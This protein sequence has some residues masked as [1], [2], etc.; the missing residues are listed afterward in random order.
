VVDFTAVTDI[1]QESDL[2]RRS[3]RETSAF[4]YSLASVIIEFDADQGR[5]GRAAFVASNLGPFGRG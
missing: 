2:A 3:F 1:W 5:K 4:S